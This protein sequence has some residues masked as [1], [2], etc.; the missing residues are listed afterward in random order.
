MMNKQKLELVGDL[1]L[2]LFVGNVLHDCRRRWHSCAF[3]I[4]FPSWR[5]SFHIIRIEI[6]KSC[7]HSH[8]LK[9]C[10]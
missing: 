9:L 8:P 6:I 3:E 10:K 5:N 2:V 7:P 4:C 1:N